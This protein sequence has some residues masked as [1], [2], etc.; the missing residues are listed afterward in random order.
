M[1]LEEGDVLLLEYGRLSET[2]H[3]HYLTLERVIALSLTSVGVTVGLSQSRVALIA[4]P[5]LLGL[6]AI[7]ALDL[8]REIVVIHGQTVWFE[9][10]VNV[11]LGTRVLQSQSWVSQPF[12]IGSRGKMTVYLMMFLTLTSSCVVGIVAALTYEDSYALAI[13]IGTCSFW[14]VWMV[15]A[16]VSAREAWEIDHRVVAWMDHNPLMMHWDLGEYRT[17]LSGR[18]ASP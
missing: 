10:R 7:Y 1:P 6:V 18:R 5:I 12:N 4:G 8:L 11:A 2:L 14:V 9:R 16:I 13:K 17:W 3:R 15:C